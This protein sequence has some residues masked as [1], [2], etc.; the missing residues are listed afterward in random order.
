MQWLKSFLDTFYNIEKLRGTLVS[1]QAWQANWNIVVAASA[2]ATVAPIPT[3]ATDFRF[4][5]R[6]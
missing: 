6:W 3:W 2:T 4:W 1:D 5:P